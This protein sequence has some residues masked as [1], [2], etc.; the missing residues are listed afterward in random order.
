MKKIR[1]TE[2]E[3]TNIIKRVINEQ[4]TIKNAESKIPQVIKEKGTE[5]ARMAQNIINMHMKYC[6]QMKSQS[7][8]MKLQNPETGQTDCEFVTKKFKEQPLWVIANL[9]KSLNAAKS[10]PTQTSP[11]RDPYWERK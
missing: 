10:L 1:L 6:Q 2:A 5:L 3:L 9:D 8:Q 7:Q 4:P 11:V